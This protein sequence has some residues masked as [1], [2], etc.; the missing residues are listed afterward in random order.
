MRLNLVIAGVW[1]IIRWYCRWL[2]NTIGC[3]TVCGTD[4]TV[5]AGISLCCHGSVLRNNGM[6][7]YRDS[8]RASYLSLLIPVFTANLILGGVWMSERMG[9]WWW[10]LHFHILHSAQTLS[11]F[12][13]SIA[14]RCATLKLPPT[15]TTGKHGARNNPPPNINIRT[16]KI[17]YS[18]VKRERCALYREKHNWLSRVFY[19]IVTGGAS[20]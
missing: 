14:Y 18:M 5:R 13:H 9:C 17:L 3:L 10:K 20:V 7:K 16:T 15:S 6:G 8:C 4:H 12:Y 2:R 1:W 11:G 19:P